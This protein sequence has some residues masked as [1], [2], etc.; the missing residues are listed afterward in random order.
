[1]L[2]NLSSHTRK[3]LVKRFGEKPGGWLWNRFTVHYT[4]KHGSWL[5]QAAIEIS[6][7]S[8]S[9]CQCRIGDMP[10]LAQ[11]ARAWIRRV[12]RSRVKSTGGSTA[13]GPEENS[14]INTE[15]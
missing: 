3:A 1:V 8:A 5:N 6:L 12:N 2:D 10:T 15:S 9:A 14:A 4:P 11:E 7:F 13:G